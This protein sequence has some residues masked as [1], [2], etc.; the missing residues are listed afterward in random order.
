MHVTNTKW[1]FASSMPKAFLLAAKLA[2]PASGGMAFNVAC[3]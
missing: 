2:H 1:D 3:S